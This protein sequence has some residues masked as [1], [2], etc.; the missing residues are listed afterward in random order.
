MPKKKNKVLTKAEQKLA[1]YKR[2]LLTSSLAVETAP[3]ISNLLSGLFDEGGQARK[4]RKAYPYPKIK[5]KKKG[6]IITPIL[7]KGF[8]DFSAENMRKAHPLPKLTPM[9]KQM[10]KRMQEIRKKQSLEKDPSGML[11]LLK[12]GGSVTVRVKLGKNKKTK[13][14]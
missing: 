3:E 14:Y 6:M 2:N 1:K 8:R 10:Q 12:K 7:P 9:Q 11:Q 5:Y 13:I 4:P